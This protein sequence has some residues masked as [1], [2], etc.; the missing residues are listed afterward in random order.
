MF[1]DG[2][3]SQIHIQVKKNTWISGTCSL[4]TKTDM[5]M[6][7]AAFYSSIQTVLSHTSGEVVRCKNVSQ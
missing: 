4:G 7:L 5:R 6:L 3:Y 1:R 2:W